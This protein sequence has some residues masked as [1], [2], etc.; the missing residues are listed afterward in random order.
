MWPLH[1]DPALAHSPWFQAM[2]ERTK[3]AGPIRMNNGPHHLSLT[4]LSDHNH[5][6]DLM[7]DIDIDIDMI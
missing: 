5:D 2:T 4:N 3:E 1:I 6:I 7:I